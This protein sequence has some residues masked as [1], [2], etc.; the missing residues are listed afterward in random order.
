MMLPL[1]RRFSYF[2]AAATML[3]MLMPPAAAASR[4]FRHIAATPCQTLRHAA[5]DFLLP[6]M[7]VDVTL[8]SRQLRYAFAAATVMRRRRVRCQAQVIAA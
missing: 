8:I 1:R 3:S 7:A 2:A 6:F 5:I 4:R